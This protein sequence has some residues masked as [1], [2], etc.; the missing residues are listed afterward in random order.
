MALPA[1]VVRTAPKSPLRLTL[2]ASDASRR[3]LVVAEYV[4]DHQGVLDRRTS[5]NDR[6]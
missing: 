1:A 4:F 2:R 3:E 6:G 5:S